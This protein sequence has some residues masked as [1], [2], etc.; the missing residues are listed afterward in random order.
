MLS[1]RNTVKTKSKNKIE[2]HISK[3]KINQKKTNES[4]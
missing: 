3:T 2:K 1:T 4:S